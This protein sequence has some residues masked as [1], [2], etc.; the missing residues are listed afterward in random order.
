MCL[1]KAR[2]IKIEEEITAE[3]FTDIFCG[4]IQAFGNPVFVHSYYGFIFEGDG[5]YI[6]YNIIDETYNCGVLDIIIFNKIPAGK[7]ISYKLYSQ[8]N[9][10]VKT[11]AIENGFRFDDITHYAE[12]QMVYLLESDRVAIF[13]IIKSNELLYFL[14]KLIPNE[15]GHRVVPQ[16]SGKESAGWSDIS[17]LREVLERIFY[18]SKSI[19]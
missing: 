3:L 8:V 18:Q 15:M 2:K 4:L 9:D 16:S 6:A 1:K 11:L 7:K 17:Q 5:K 13:F 14:S 12:N 10:T 19:E